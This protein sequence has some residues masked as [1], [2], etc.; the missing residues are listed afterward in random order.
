MRRVAPALLLALLTWACVQRDVISVTIAQVSVQPETIPAAVGATVRFTGTVED[1]DGRIFPTARVEWSVEKPEIATVDSE[2]A[3]TTL[4]PG[5]TEIYATFRNV[6]GVGTLV[7][8]VPPAIALNP[9][10]VL[11]AA[12]SGAGQPDPV[13][14][15]VSNSSESGSLT[16]LATQTFYDAPPEGWLQVALSNTRA[17]ADISLSADTDGLP[18]GDYEATVAI[19][20]PDDPSGPAAL[21]V[22]LSVVGVSIDPD[23]ALSIVESAAPDTIR[24]S[25]QTAPDTAV[26][27]A[28]ASAD[29]TEV[30]ATPATLTFTPLDW[31]IP[32]IIE[33]R[34]VD[35][36]VADGDQTVDIVIS[37][38]DD[39]SDDRFDPILNDT[40]S[41]TSL[42]DDTPDI[43][44]VE[45]G[46]STSVDEA[47]STDQFTVVLDVEPLSP[48]VFEIER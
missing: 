17:P 10:S 33:V 13:A 43:T 35:E 4:A 31:D 39:L 27:L 16:N 45:T 1:A 19:T 20:S 41:V 48:V 37:V 5:T 25:L 30:T 8:A 22:R 26:V 12:A 47:G 9:D 46:G 38:D 7:V 23:T 3:V 21:V 15:L 40:I 34:G 42:D 14:V 28:V 6:V 18:V 36:N 11:I 32:Q 2:G 29:P 24:V 44:I